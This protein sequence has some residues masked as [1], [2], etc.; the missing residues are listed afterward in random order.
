MTRERAG[1][2]ALLDVRRV[3]ARWPELVVVVCL[4][5]LVGSV[6]SVAGREWGRVVLTV[7]A[8]ALATRLAR[9]YFAWI[10]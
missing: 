2:L 3:Q 6:T 5:S 1:W 8:Y 7:L 4:A 10:A 9:W